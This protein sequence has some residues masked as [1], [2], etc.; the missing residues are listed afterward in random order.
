MSRIAS[1]IWRFEGIRTHSQR[2]KVTTRVPLSVPA[3][4][5]GI[6]VGPT[7]VTALSISATSASS[8]GIPWGGVAGVTF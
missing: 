7:T 8:A 4:N 5:Q 1:H 3:K 6:G 2:C